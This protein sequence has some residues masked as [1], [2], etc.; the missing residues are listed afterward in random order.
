MATQ[1]EQ[2]R[3]ALTIDDVVTYRISVS[4]TDKGDLPDQFIFVISIN[5]ETDSKEDTFARVAT[6]ADFTEIQ[7]SRLN[8][9]NADET[10]YR[11]SSFILYYDNLET[12]INAQTV[13][14]EKIDELVSDYEDYEAD[15]ETVV[16]EVTTHPQLDQATYDA[17]V[18]AYQDA[19]RDTADA[20]AERDEKEEAYNDKVVECSDANTAAT[21]SQ[22]IADDCATTKG[23]FDVL[24]TAFIALDADGTTFVTAAQTYYQNKVISPVPDAFDVAF[25]AAINDMLADLRTSAAAKTQ[26]ATDKA[27]FATICGNRSTENSTAQTAKTTCDTELKQAKTDFDDAQAA[28]ETALQAQNAAL[29]A[30]QALKPDFDPTS[31]DPSPV[32][33]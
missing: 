2:I 28:V 4:V 16:A 24:E 25:L 20:E 1:T 19:L 30:V 33:A 31:V 27:D 13:L 22:E 7:S 18:T 26:A 14:K 6:I 9:V 12:A 3:E 11:T 29:A 8:A 23:Y 17:A 10:L 15:F 32:E 5:D 21:K